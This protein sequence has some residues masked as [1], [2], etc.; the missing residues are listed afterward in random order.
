MNSPF[1]N[2]LIF[3]TDPNECITLKKLRIGFCYVVD[4]FDY[5]P[6]FR[7]I[8]FGY[9]KQSID[10]RLPGRC[11]FVY[12][13]NETEE[14]F[15]LLMV[16]SL[17]PNWSSA[18]NII[19]R[20]RQRKPAMKIIVGGQHISQLPRLL[21]DEADFGI[22]G[23][24]EV[25]TPLLLNLIINNVREEQHY[26]SIDGIVFKGSGGLFISPP[27]RLTFAFIPH[28]DRLFQG[29]EKLVPYLLT[30]RGCPYNCS[31]CSSSSLWKTVSMQSAESVAEEIEFIAN[32]FP[33]TRSL[34]FWDDLF[35][36]DR[37]RLVRLHALLQ[38]KQLLNRFNYSCNVRADLVDD[39]LCQ[40]LRNLNIRSCG[41]GFEHGVDRLLNLLKPQGKCTVD[42]NLNA[43]RTL[44]NNGIAVGIGIV[45]GAPTETEEDVIATYELTHKLLKYRFIAD[46]SYNILMPMP[47]TFYWQEALK[48]N[49]VEESNHYDWNKL[50]VFADYH[51]SNCGSLDAWIDERRRRKSV[52]LNE[53][54]LPE[55]RL[56]EIMKTYNAKFK[57]IIANVRN[58]QPL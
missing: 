56:L 47:G 42:A 51:N 32:H 38:E 9:L 13:E 30:S 26:Q 6:G 39:D 11:D 15:D 24:G 34:A 3:A 16:S 23:E 45:F 8:G 31:F 55:T 53:D 48:Q 2:R 33:H 18:L 44:A 25:S 41:F 36:A 5:N 10:E 22:L 17:S 54:H 14:E 21:P 57:Q 12:F 58:I 7:P 35:V 37:K 27:K 19:K 4:R 46:V 43:A 28:P 50:S 29:G 40:L 49:L 1:R 52:Y 20:Y